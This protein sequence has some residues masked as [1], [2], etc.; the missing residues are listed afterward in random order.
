LDKQGPLPSPTRISVGGG[1]GAHLSLLEKP[2]PLL[3]LYT[4]SI[5]FFFFFDGSVIKSTDCSSED[6]EF[7]S[8]QPHGGSQPSVKRFEAQHSLGTKP[9][10]ALSG[11]LPS[12][13]CWHLG[14]ART[15]GSQ[16]STPFGPSGIWVHRRLRTT[17]SVPDLAAFH[18]GEHRLG[19]LSRTVF[20]LL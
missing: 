9:E 10:Y 17:A 7:K 4:F 11:A 6:P 5:H 3:A 12:P 20:C 2:L 15:C 8:Q 16:F 1:G 14:E 18:P 19:P 13:S